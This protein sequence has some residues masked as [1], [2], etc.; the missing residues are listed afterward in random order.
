VEGKYPLTIPREDTRKPA[1]P[2][3]EMKKAT[4]RLLELETS[5]STSKI[6]KPKKVPKRES[7]RRDSDISLNEDSV[8]SEDNSAFLQD[9]DLLDHVSDN[10]MSYLEDEI[11]NKDVE[12]QQRNSP[13]TEKPAKRLREKNK[14][15]MEISS[16]SL[17][18]EDDEMEVDGL[19]STAAT[20]NSVNDSDFLIRRRNTRNSE[21][22]MNG[23]VLRK[24][25]KT[26]PMKIKSKLQSTKKG[27]KTFNNRH[28]L[29][30]D[31]NTSSGTKNSLAQNATFVELKRSKKKTPENSTNDAA[32]RKVCF[33]LAKNL[34]HRKY[35]IF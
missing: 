23:D 28:S 32:K 2:R 3:K 1:V 29:P 7:M 25:K 5:D 24:I 15:E 33:V 18:D 14:S 9:D 8:G 13:K 10:Y 12:K 4:L 35:S 34:E 19:V 31:L 16:L 6:R 11:Q 26:T 20:N 22:G 17:N 21:P 27:A 30:S